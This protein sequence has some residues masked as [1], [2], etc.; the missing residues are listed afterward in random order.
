MT[1]HISFAGI[2]SKVDYLKDLGVG[3]VWLSPIYESPMKDNGY[4]VK[5]YRKIDSSFGSMQDFK[6]LLAKLKE[7]GIKLIM[8]FVPNHTSDQHEWFRA[9]VNGDAEKKDYYVWRDGSPSTPP[10]DWV[11]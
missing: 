11:T 10:N 9:A 5:D 7:N 3:S 2:A 6:D 1:G 8:D 4:D